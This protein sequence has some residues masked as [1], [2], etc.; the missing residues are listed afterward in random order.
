MHESSNGFMLNHDEQTRS[1]TGMNSV[2][3]SQ[4]ASRFWLPFDVKLF[5][6]LTPREY[7][8]KYC[9]VNNRRHALYKRIFDKHKDSEG[10]LSVKALPDALLDSYMRTID[11]HFISQVIGLLD[12]SSNTKITFAQFEGIAAFS[13][14]YFFNIF[15]RQDNMEPQL[16]KEILEKLDFSSLKWKLVGVNISSSLRQILRLL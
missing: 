8:E 11:S 7:L 5:E 13:E 3:L 14:R 12:L 6:T 9:R 16:Q 2:I 10:E 15:T 1:Y 4:Q